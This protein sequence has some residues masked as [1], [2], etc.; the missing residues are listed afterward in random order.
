MREVNRAM[1]RRERLARTA[2]KRILGQCLDRKQGGIKGSKRRHS[3][4]VGV[5]SRKS[6]FKRRQ[7]Q[8]TTRGAG[9]E[10]GAGGWGEENRDL[11][12]RP[13]RLPEKGDNFKNP[14]G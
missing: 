8:K 4:S 2:L 12:A 11:S 10:G 3:A 5:L 7:L 9:G 1:G 14:H 6:I 13:K